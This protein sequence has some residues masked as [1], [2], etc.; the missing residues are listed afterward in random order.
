MLNGLIFFAAQRIHGNCK[1]V[2]TRSCVPQFVPATKFP[3]ARLRIH[4]RTVATTKNCICRIS[5]G[6]CPGSQI[7][8]PADCAVEQVLRVVEWTIQFFGY[9]WCNDYRMNMNRREKSF[10]VDLL[11]R[12][13]TRDA[14]SDEAR[15]GDS[16]VP[17]ASLAFVEDD[18]V[19][20]SYWNLVAWVAG[21]QWVT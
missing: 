13:I 21:R 19:V 17:A 12:Y 15:M 3:A 20:K 7:W 5:F 6:L 8:Y 4:P 18:C 10:H 2:V 16:A 9:C 1:Q 11:K 14:L